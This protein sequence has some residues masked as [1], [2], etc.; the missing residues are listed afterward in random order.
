MYVYRQ[1]GTL[2][3][4]HTRCEGYL[5]ETLGLKNVLG[6]AGYG[7]H[8]RKGGMYYTPTGSI[9]RH[10]IWRGWSLWRAKISI[11]YRRYLQILMRLAYRL[12]DTLKPINSETNHRC[13]V[14][15]ICFIFRAS[16]NY[17]Q[18]V[19]VEVV[20]VSLPTLLCLWWFIVLLT[21]NHLKDTVNRVS[22]IL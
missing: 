7:T 17:P 13:V 5:I 21:P 9:I 22:E 19:V 11:H 16:S 6:T 3:H 18:A 12:I 15:T 8:L 1:I 20:G 10:V 14:E 4:R 2:A